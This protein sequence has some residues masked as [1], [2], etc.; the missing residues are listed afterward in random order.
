MTRLVLVTRPDGKQYLAVSTLATGQDYPITDE[1]CEN[2][3]GEVCPQVSRFIACFPDPCAD[4][5]EELYVCVPIA[6]P[7]IKWGGRCYQAVG[8]IIPIENVP[9]GSV[10]LRTGMYDCVDGCADDRCVPQCPRYR[11]AT[12]C[13][14]QDDP[15]C[16]LYLPAQFGGG[17]C[18]TFRAVERCWFID[19]GTPTVIEPDIPLGACIGSGF[20]QAGSIQVGKTCC[21][22]VPGCS[23]SFPPQ[24]PCLGPEC[25]PATIQ[26]LECCC[27]IAGVYTIN[28][29]WRFSIEQASNTN[30]QEQ[31]HS[32]IIEIDEFGNTVSL[33]GQ[34]SRRDIFI[35]NT[36]GTVLQ[37]TTQPVPFGG[38]PWT[39]GQDE[40]GMKVYQFSGGFGFWLGYCP[41]QFPFN[42][43][44]VYQHPDGKTTNIQEALKQVS[45]T[46]YNA[47]GKYLTLP[48]PGDVEFIRQTEEFRSTFTASYRGA[49]SG[50]CGSSP[51]PPNGRAQLG[52][53]GGTLTNTN[54][55]CAACGA[56][57]DLGSGGA[58]I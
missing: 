24:Y 21:T 50:G 57:A 12:M 11:Q 36:T 23:P 44:S 3:C 31:T 10:V 29:F 15:P 42:G 47:R 28:A 55:G 40:C 25:P 5:P 6:C 8:Q 22:C 45:C 35:D 16:A 43:S 1:G 37:D 34:A 56:S 20:V 17:Q 33:T 52:V 41:S 48:G 39:C 32:W 4:E 14:G 53:K 58:T 2:C 27:S 9:D 13:P 19:P 49:C 26:P 18:V 46:R 54:T 38:I 7:Q 51:P 30:T